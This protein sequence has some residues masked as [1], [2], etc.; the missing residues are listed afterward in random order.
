M[1]V[2]LILTRLYWDCLKFLFIINIIIIITIIDIIFWSCLTIFFNH[3][4]NL[5][6]DI[7][8]TKLNSIPCKNFAAAVWV[9]YNQ[10]YCHCLCGVQRDLNWH[11]LWKFKCS[12]GASMYRK[13][14]A[15]MSPAVA[16]VSLSNRIIYCLQSVICLTI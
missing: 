1:D 2:Y 15:K 13:W 12:N 8:Y 10:W 9:V 3:V 6:P 14:N 4:F 16:N 7:S 11:L 5:E